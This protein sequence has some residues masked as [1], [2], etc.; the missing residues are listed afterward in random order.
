MKYGKLMWAPLGI[1]LAGILVLICKKHVMGVQRAA[2][3]LQGGGL[4]IPALAGSRG[5]P[6]RLFAIFAGA[7][8]G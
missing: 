2:E 4:V 8:S 6:V 7:A 5:A 1:V 3:L